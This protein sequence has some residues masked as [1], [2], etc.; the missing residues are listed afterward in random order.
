MNLVATAE[1]GR[2]TLGDLRRFCKKIAVRPDGC[3]EWQAF[4]MAHGYGQFGAR[5]PSGRHRMFYAHRVAYSW[6]IGPI[7]AGLTLDHLCANPWCVN[8]THLE[9]VSGSENTK[10]ASARITHCKYGHEFDEANT[11]RNKST[12]RRECR[13][14]NARRG[15]ELRLRRAA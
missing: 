9:P 7:P 4:R 2:A 6:L 13:A 15:R 8:P 3:W 1:I 5:R 10:R 14:C 12:G 11:Y